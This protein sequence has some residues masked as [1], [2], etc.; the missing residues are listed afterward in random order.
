[1]HKV[2]HCWSGDGTMILCECNMADDHL[3]PLGIDTRIE[4][5][6]ATGLLRCCKATALSSA[7]REEIFKLT[8]TNMRSIYEQT[9][10]WD[11]DQ[12]SKVS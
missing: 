8:E 1:M 7:Q 4:L 10:G 3:T 5:A 2:G 12:R 9:W 6:S 11:K